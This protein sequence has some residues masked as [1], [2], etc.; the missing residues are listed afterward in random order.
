[1]ENH[2]ARLLCVVLQRIMSWT[3][4]RL[5]L[6]ECDRI[7]LK[8]D[9]ARMFDAEVDLET[10]V[11]TRAEIE[12]LAKIDTRCGTFRRNKIKQ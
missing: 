3:S 10:V 4:S 12:L 7:Y 8:I 1:M 2:A 11:N 9:C 6:T 5:G